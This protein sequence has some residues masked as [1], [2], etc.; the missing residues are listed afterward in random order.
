MRRGD[1]GAP[2]AKALNSTEGAH[3]E[4]MSIL[5]VYE[6]LRLTPRTG[7]RQHMFGSAQK[8]AALHCRE[9]LVWHECAD[10]CAA[11]LTECSGTAD[12]TDTQLLKEFS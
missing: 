3:P 6:H 12:M 4:C 9:L 1:R 7:Q 5:G 8:D 10:F 2:L 11:T